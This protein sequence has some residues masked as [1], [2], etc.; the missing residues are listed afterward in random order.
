RQAI[1]EGVTKNTETNQGN[2]LFGTF[3]CCEV[4]GGE[5]EII[6][7]NVSL[8]HKPGELR[9]QRNN[10][11]FS[12]TLVRASINIDFDELLERALIFRGNPHDPPFDYVDRTYQGEGDAVLFAVAKEI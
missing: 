4:S 11:P 2:G 10:I 1:E 5:F 3:K 9:V 8:K 12:G 7:G 6:S